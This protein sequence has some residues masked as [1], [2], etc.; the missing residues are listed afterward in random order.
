MS[1]DVYRPAKEISRIFKLFKDYL[2]IRYD[3]FKLEITENLVKILSGFYVF[4][5]LVSMLTISAMFFSFAA[6]YFLGELFNSLPLGFSLIG[7]FYLI[8]IFVF[9]LLRKWIITRPILKFVSKI[10][11][12]KKA[13]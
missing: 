2:Q 6:A 1:S 3:I 7:I 5:V 9:I 12:N 11:F 4:F 8:M 13:G 10:F